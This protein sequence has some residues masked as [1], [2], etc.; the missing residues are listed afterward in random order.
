M[1]DHLIDTRTHR[2][3][4]TQSIGT[5]GRAIHQQRLVA[6]V[7]GMRLDPR[8]RRAVLV[9]ALSEHTELN[10]DEITELLGFGSPASMR[11]ALSRARAQRSTDSDIGRALDDLER[12]LIGLRAA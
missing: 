11:T 5:D 2:V 3:L 6:L 9:I 12:E 8:T 7:D 4:V 1:V 10:A